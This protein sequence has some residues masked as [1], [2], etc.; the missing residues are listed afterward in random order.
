MGDDKEYHQLHLNAVCRL[1]I[2]ANMLESSKSECYR[3][4]ITYALHT[5]LYNSSKIHVF[6]SLRYAGY[7]KNLPVRVNL[8][9][10]EI[11]SYQ[12]L[13]DDDEN[14]VAASEDEEKEEVQH[15]CLSLA[16]EV[17][18]NKAVFMQIEFGRTLNLTET[19]SQ[20]VEH[21]L[22][23][24]FRPLAN[25]LNIRHGTTKAFNT[26][27]SFR[28]LDFNNKRKLGAAVFFE[29]YEKHKDTLYF[30]KPLIAADNEAPPSTKGDD[31]PNA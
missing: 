23:C 19:S 3:T 29:F 1:V 11:F 10:H 28:S 25:N 20:L 26:L 27:E 16:A 7:T 12:E 5:Q 24:L 30:A 17:K 8:Y 4:A 18:A 15:V 6:S 13:V 14:Q 2:D 21:L 22:I 9:R 31:Y